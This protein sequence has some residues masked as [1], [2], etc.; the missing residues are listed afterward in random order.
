M[1]MV[2]PEPQTRGRTRS[3][4]LVLVAAFTASSLGM[5]AYLKRSKAAQ[6]AEEVARDAVR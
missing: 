2:A 6:V 4:W 5:I 3:E 1:P